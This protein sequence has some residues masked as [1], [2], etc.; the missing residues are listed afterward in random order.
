MLGT[1]RDCIGPLF[2]VLRSREGKQRSGAHA[3]MPS[4][5]GW[6]LS[7]CRLQYWSRPLTRNWVCDAR[8]TE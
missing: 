8:N 7:D 1:L 4:Y 2:K 6:A 3:E 5:H